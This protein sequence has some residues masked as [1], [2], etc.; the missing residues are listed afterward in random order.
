M[1]KSAFVCLLWSIALPAQDDATGLAST[2][3][4]T[5]ADKLKDVPRSQYAERQSHWPLSSEHGLSLGDSHFRVNISG[6]ALKIALQ[7]GAVPRKSVR[8]GRCYKLRYQFGG[9]RQRTMNIGFTRELDNTWSWY[10]ADT[11][12]VSLANQTIRLVDANADGRF[13]IHQDGYLVPGARAICPLNDTLILGATEVRI[14][15]LAD[16]GSHLRVSERRIPGTKPQLSA[17]RILNQLRSTN[18]LP[19]VLLSVDLSEGCTIYARRLK[20]NEWADAANPSLKSDRIPG[21]AKQRLAGE[22]NTMVMHA[23]NEVAIQ[24]YWRTWFHRR[25][26][27]DPGMTEIGINAAPADIS[28][29]DAQHGKPQESDWSWPIC[30]PTDGAIDIPLNARSELPNEPV[31][32]LSARGFPIMAMFHQALSDDIDFEGSLVAVI[33]G[34]AR[35]VRTIIGD[36]DKHP[37][38]FGIVPETPLLRDTDYIA[39]LQWRTGTAI[40]KRVI[41]FRSQQ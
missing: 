25:H 18:G 1:R 29:I 36:S 22:T 40:T 32:N 15:T 20:A 13:T 4:I 14:Q 3:I 28:V 17:L 12:T 37:R 34:R 31:K 9:G 26:L 21:H 2:L 33:N 5:Q 35:K 38:L 11:R 7:A 23:T 30:V 10:C 8:T 6:A 24:S 19:G 16:N 41:H 39:T 27:M